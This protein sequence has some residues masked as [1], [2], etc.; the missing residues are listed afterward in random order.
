MFAKRLG[1]ILNARIFEI[2]LGVA[3]SATT[4][5]GTFKGGGVGVYLTVCVGF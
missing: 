2:D 1:L 5:E 3:S 4:I